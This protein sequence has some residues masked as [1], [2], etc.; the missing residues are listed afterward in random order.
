MRAG[1]CL[2]KRDLRTALVARLFLCTESTCFYWPRGRKLYMSPASNF[3]VSQ[4]SN[5]K[6]L[7]VKNYTDL[8]CNCQKA[9]PISPPPDLVGDVNPCNRV[10]FLDQNLQQKVL[11]YSRKLWPEAGVAS[12]WFQVLLLKG[13]LS[14]TSAPAHTGST[15]AHVPFG[16][17]QGN[18]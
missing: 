1:L 4:L 7:C 3:T 15:H 6:H 14:P 16:R 11:F 17:G 8:V 13:I 18:N 12:L 2:P 10:A 5:K 9:I